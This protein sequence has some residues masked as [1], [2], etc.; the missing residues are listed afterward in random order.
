MYWELW[1]AE[2]NSLILSLTKYSEHELASSY[3]PDISVYMICR[4]ITSIWFIFQENPSNFDAD[5]D[6]VPG[7]LFK[8]YCIFLQSK[9]FW[10]IFFAYFYAKT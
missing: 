1:G 5:P 3:F 8:I 9:I 10:Q 7:F 4:M 2:K 6:P